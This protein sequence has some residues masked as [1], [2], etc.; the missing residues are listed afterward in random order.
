MYY[1]IKLYYACKISVNT[2]NI[3]WVL[4][5]C[6]HFSSFFSSVAPSVALLWFCSFISSESRQILR[7]TLLFIGVWVPE[8][9]LDLFPWRIWDVQCAQS[10]QLHLS[11]LAYA[12]RIDKAF[13]WILKSM[14]FWKNLLEASRM[15]QILQNNLNALRI[16]Q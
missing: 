15:F 13:H 4:S 6:I 8:M 12:W 5:S 14:I 2:L 11:W 16:F 10:L 1:I 9:C 7:R 3:G